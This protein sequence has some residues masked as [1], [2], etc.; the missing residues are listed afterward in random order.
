MNDNEPTIRLHEGNTTESSEK[1]T[2]ELYFNHSSLR[3]LAE[4]SLMTK[5]I[6]YSFFLSCLFWICRQNKKNKF[7]QL[8]N[9]ANQEWITKNKNNN[10]NNSKNKK[11]KEARNKN[12]H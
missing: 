11:Q 5:K 6:E 12:K 10:N 7:C 2:A 9:K 1:G 8:H 4:V 3:K